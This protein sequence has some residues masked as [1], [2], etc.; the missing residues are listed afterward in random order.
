MQA[1]M[2]VGGNSAFEGIF[3]CVS[4]SATAKTNISF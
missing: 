1:G 2:H 4:V 3:A